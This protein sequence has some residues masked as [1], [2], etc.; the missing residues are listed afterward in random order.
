MNGTMVTTFL[1]ALN[2]G[3]GFAG[4]TDWRIPNLN[5]LETI[6]NIQNVNPAVDSAFNT[7]C[8]ATCTV[9]SCSCTRSNFY[10]SSSTYQGNPYF[11]WLVSFDDGY[12]F[13]DGKIYNYSV[14]A[15]R[16]GS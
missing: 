6:R 12:A 14:R 2:G 15:V 11:A 16:G 7:G 8:V 1:A 10:W 4:Y 5:E 13:Y 9:T 3:G